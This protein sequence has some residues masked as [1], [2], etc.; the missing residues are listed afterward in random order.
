MYYYRNLKPR[1]IVEPLVFG[2]ISP[3]DYKFFCKDGNVVMIQVDIDRHTNHV[4]ALYQKNWTKHNFSIGYPF[5]PAQIS[6][7]DNLAEMIEVAETLSNGFD[8]LRVD[9]YSNNLKVK[10]GELTNCHGNALEKIVST[11]ASSLSDEIKF[12][13]Q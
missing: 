6:A 1:I 4:R 13:G 9:M 12:F 8:Y 11:N 3:N 2:D 10:V 5:N 7:P